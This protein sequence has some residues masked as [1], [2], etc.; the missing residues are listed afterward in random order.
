MNTKD[1]AKKIQYFDDCYRK[2]DAKISDAE[3]DEL[4]KQF[5]ARNPNHPAIN[6]EGMKLL[7]LGNSCFSEWWADKARN[8]TMIVQPKFDG[9]A[10]WPYLPTIR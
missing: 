3:F 5:K 4:V 6:P 8:E 1:L 7:S 10:F 2:G 9:C